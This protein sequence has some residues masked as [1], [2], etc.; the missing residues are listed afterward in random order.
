M[1]AEL[2]VRDVAGAPPPPPRP[3]IEVAIRSRNLDRVV[4]R[5]KLAVSVEALT[6]SNDVKLVATLGKRTLAKKADIDLV[7]G[8]V[9][10][11]GLKLRN[12]GQEALA[13][14]DKARV[15]LKGTVPFGFPDVSRRVLR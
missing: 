10:K 7:A 8:Q 3:D 12:K 6:D 4:N 15:K 1:S 13:D 14:R 5:G 11:L 2:V 9:L